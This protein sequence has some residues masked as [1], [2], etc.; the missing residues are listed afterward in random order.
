MTTTNNDLRLQVSRHIPH[1]PEKV[2]DAW[3]DPGMLTRFMTPG[4]GMTVADARADASEGGRF[5]VVM[6]TPDGND[7]PHEGTYKTIDRPRQLVFTWE[8]PYTTEDS[9]VTLDFADAEGGTDVTL[10]HVR[11]PDEQ[12]RDN[13]E[14]GWTQILASLDAAL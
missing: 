1:A 4:P 2:F 5:R 12:S 3:L 11:F 13:H 6:R 9:T 8:S 14:G 7:L 10:T